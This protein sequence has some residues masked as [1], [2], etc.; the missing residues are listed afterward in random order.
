MNIKKNDGV[1]LLELIIAMVLM[2]LVLSLC[3][4]VFLSGDSLIRDNSSRVNSYA[5]LVSMHIAKYAR[6][7]ASNYSITSNSPDSGDVTLQYR[8]NSGPLDNASITSMYIFD[9]SEEE[10]IY[11]QDITGSSIVISK[12]I[13]SFTVPTVPIVPGI[14]LQVAITSVDSEGNTCTLRTYIQP[15]ATAFPAVYTI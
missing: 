14:G 5:Q 13:Q 8:I 9:S 11:Y 6:N 2:L 15:T 10:I 1:T 12:N 7:A 3:G 4:S